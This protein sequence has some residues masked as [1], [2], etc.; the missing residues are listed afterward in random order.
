MR[1]GAYRLTHAMARDG[2]LPSVFATLSGRH[3]VPRGAAIAA[4]L[5]AAPF[6]LTGRIGLVAS[7]TD[8]LVYA[9][10]LVVNG[11]VIALRFR[12]P[13]VART[14]RTPWALGRV[15]VLPVLGVLAV[16]LMLA[17]LDRQAAGIGAAILGAGVLAWGALRL[18]RSW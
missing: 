13:E 6:A 11:A 17:Y 14:F 8:F 7:A 16:V 15:P 4:L 2:E 1:L 12:A 3:A 5:V 18:A 9:I 10:F